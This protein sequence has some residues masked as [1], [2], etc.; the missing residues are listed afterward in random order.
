MQ[1]KSPTPDKQDQQSCRIQSEHGKK[2]LSL[3]QH[4]IYQERN[5]G[6]IPFTIV[7][8]VLESRKWKTST[9]TSKY[10]IEK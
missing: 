7:I 2:S 9:T 6:I 8:K 3:Y 10:C 1:K 5:Q 4:L